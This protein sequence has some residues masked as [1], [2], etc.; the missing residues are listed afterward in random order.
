MTLREKIESGQFVKG[1]HINLN[2]PSIAKIVSKLGF[3]YIW[4]DCEH[5]YL[6]YE[7]LLSHIMTIQAAGGTAIVRVPQHDFTAT[8]KIIEMGPDGIVFPMIRSKE[9][10]DELVSYTLYPPE[11]NRGFGPNNAVSYG[12]EDVQEYI[13]NNKKMLRFI[14]I[15][16]IN[17]VNDLE[18]V[19]KNP[20]IDGYIFGAQD[21]SGS[22]GELTNV[23]GENTQ[24]LI[25]KSIEVLKKNN[26]VIGIS[27]NENDVATIQKWRDMGIQMISAGSDFTILAM[28]MKE[29]FENISKIN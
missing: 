17:L 22:I 6:S 12:L 24:S 27:I 16:H 3:D 19:I 15:E 18:N 2:D 10:A 4:I 20:Y 14:Q 11:G 7:N 8:K 28:G 13:H 26:K 9:E 21:L 23:F 25:K 5:S 1:T 29:T